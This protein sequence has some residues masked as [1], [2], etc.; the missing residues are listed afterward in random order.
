LK[1]GDAGWQ[2]ATGQ[3]WRGQLGVAKT[4]GSNVLK[5][6]SR[7]KARQLWHVKNKAFS[8]SVTLP[9]QDRVLPTSKASVSLEPEGKSNPFGRLEELCLLSLDL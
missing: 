3:G 1:E 6:Q 8:L 5:V 4:P 2:V 9:S 7:N